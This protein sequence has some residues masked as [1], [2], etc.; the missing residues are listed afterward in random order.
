MIKTRRKPFYS[1]KSNIFSAMTRVI[2]VISG[3]G[4]VGKTTT[5]ANLGT[6][7]VHKG[8]S[9]IV[10]DANITTP[11][12]S[13]HLGIPLYPITLHDV[14]KKRADM[15]EAV[16][17][18]SSGL[19]VI[20]A[21]LSINSMKGVKM[22]KLHTAIINLLGASDFI[23][24]DA[25][26]GLGNEAQA[27]IDVADEV[28]IVTNPEITALTDA[29]KTVKIAEGVGTKVLG[30]VVNRRRGHNHEYTVPQIEDMLETE[31]LSTI[32]E[33]L[34]VPRSIA[35]KMP[36][37]HYSPRSKSSRQF[38]NLASIITGERWVEPARSK[39]WYEKLF[40]WMA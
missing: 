25:A 33:D 5:T 8:H 39:K 3:K 12:L 13:L 20:P 28:I 16:Y 27:A 17:T 1:F 23:L 19:K 32:P 38:K 22:S 30:A 10:L 4:G 15:R 9:V 7:L 37:V 40:S 18:H 29:L 31:V 21:S 36:V 34:A 6:A 14:L 26:A 11:N 2:T 24:I 35:N